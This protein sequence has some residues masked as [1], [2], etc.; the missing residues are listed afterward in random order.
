MIRAILSAF[1]EAFGGTFLAWL[2][3]RRAEETAKEVGALRAGLETANVIA[4]VANERAALPPP[5][6]TVDDLARR[7]RE[8]AAALDRG[9]AGGGGGTGVA[10]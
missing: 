8:R 5:P 7:L 6:V 1:L 9:R 4:E 10:G 3:D 2:R